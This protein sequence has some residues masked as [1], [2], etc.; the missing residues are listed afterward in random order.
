MNLIILRESV[1]AE[2]SAEIKHY[3]LYIESTYIQE[4]LCE[5]CK[6]ATETSVKWLLES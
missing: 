3:K 1:I 2:K 4:G 5:H 6:K